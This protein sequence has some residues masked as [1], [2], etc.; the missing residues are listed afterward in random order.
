M[1]NKTN[2]KEKDFKIFRKWLFDKFEELISEMFIDFVTIS[3]EFD[4][5]ESPDTLDHKGMTSVF[6]IEHDTC[7]HKSHIVVYPVAYKLYHTDKIKLLDTMVHELCH[8]HTEKLSSLAEKRY[9]SRR[10]ISDETENLTEIM[11]KYVTTLLKQTTKI[12]PPSNN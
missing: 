4:S 5:R 3:F 10:E 1:K 2:N 9:L 12:Y 7:Y 11:S 8:T 6:S